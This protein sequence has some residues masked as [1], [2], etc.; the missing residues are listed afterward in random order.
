MSVPGAFPPIELN[1]RLLIDGGIVRNVPVDIVREMGA[2]IIICIDLDKPMA[3]RKDLGGS[4]S[5]LNQM[6][7]IMMKKNVKEQLKNLGPQDVYI[8]PELGELGSTDFD[9]AAEISQLGEKAAR[10]K[11][12]SLK[13]YS[14]NETEYAAFTA[15]HH[16]EQIKEI[17]VASVQIEVQGKSKISPDYVASR[18]TVKPGDTI[19]VEE[20]KSQ[21]GIVYGTGDFERVDL[22]AIKKQED[23][24]LV[25]KAKEKS[26]GP[27]YLRVGLSL[28]TDFKG[29][30]TYNILLDYTR[31]WI[32]SL[33]A[34]WKTQVNLGTPTGIYSEFYQPL[35]VNRLFFIS[36]HI[37]WKQNPVDVWDGHH[38][39]AEYRITSY[40]G[41][42]DFGIQPWMYGEARIGLQFGN[43][44]A[45]KITGGLDLPTD[46]ITR[47][48]V[49]VQ[50]RLDQLD[51]VNFPNNGYLVQFK[52]I[53]A[54]KS[55]GSDDEYNKVLGSAVGA[56]TFKKQTVIAS[57][58]AG[59]FIGN[60]LPYY[61]TFTLGG[62]INL[63]GLITGQLRGQ[64]MAIGKLVTY[65]KI[66]SSFIGDLYFGG[67][68]ESGNVWQKEEK[69]FDLENLRLAGSVFIGYD[70]LFGPLYIVYGHADGGYDAGYFY[71][72][73][74]F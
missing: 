68:V 63:S 27:N 57:F 15:R 51:N 23:Y 49:V 32:N 50:A 39:I 25:V 7:D 3:T 22:Y 70:T 29:S 33:G 46:N 66:G 65:H 13:K 59:S 38:R 53:S 8:N 37:E 71:L 14:V 26:W 31:R 62:F 43:F 6:I 74:P 30:S 47:G 54:L 21:A 2:D 41:G 40:E 36:P 45:S 55:L 61:D 19:D 42:I 34:E 1:N 73:R 20:M 10:E 35:A 12:G 69:N 28:E 18:L 9:K 48:A 58:T 52:S 17:K 67:S 44:R 16:R 24:D 64:S 11:I 72:G 4:L 56:F 5:V 60:E